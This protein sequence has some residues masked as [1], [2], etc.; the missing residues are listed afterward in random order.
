MSG[1]MASIVSMAVIVVIMTVVT[2]TMNHRCQPDCCRKVNTWPAGSS[3]ASS[4]TLIAAAASE[5]MIATVPRSLKDRA[6]ALPIMPITADQ[7]QVASDDVGQETHTKH[8]VLDERTD[9]LDKDDPQIT[10]LEG[11]HHRGRSSFG[12]ILVQKPMIPGSWNPSR[13]HES[14]CR[15]AS[16]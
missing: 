6:A 7:H 2:V 9:D 10:I 4:R 5:A 12:I 11:E 3:T 16:S 15:S 1:G 13:S 14:A 8:P